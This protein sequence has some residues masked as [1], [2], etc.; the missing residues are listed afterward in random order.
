MKHIEMHELW[1]QDRVAKLV[2]EITKVKGDENVADGLTK[3]VVRAKMAHYM[4][5]CGIVRR[6]GR[7]DMCP[8]L[9]GDK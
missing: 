7:P 8:R 2:L 4:E 6:S 1:V 5:E 3:H 9:G